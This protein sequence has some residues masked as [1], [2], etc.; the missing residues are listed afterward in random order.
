MGS[1]DCG[2]DAIGDVRLLRRVDAMLP[3]FAGG[4]V[5][6]VVE[7]RL[8]PF[9]ADALKAGKDACAPKGCVRSRATASQTHRRLGFLSL[10]CRRPRVRGILLRQV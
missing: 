8:N 10:R 5:V 9:R 1:W 3:T 4:L 7:W 2:E 6:V